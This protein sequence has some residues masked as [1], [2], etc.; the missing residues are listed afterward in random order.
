MISLNTILSI[1]PLVYEIVIRLVPTAKSY[2]LLTIAE[3]IVSAIIPNLTND[4]NGNLVNMNKVNSVV[5]PLIVP[6]PGEPNIQDVNNNTNIQSK[7]P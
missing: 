6:E 4:G 7:A 2:S 1:L 5:T 3:Q